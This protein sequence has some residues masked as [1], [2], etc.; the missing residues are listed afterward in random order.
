MRVLVLGGAGA[1][2]NETTRDLAE[3]S[4]FGEIVVA[5]YNLEAAEA[6]VKEV[7]DQRLKAIHFDAEDYVSML[8]LFPDFDQT[9]PELPLT[10]MGFEIPMIFNPRPD[11]NPKLKEEVM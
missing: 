8:N 3:F 1:V 6:L 5:D 2:C 7:G 4:D 11:T 9:A 10:G